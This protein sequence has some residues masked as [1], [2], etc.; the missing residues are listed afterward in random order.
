MAFAHECHK[1]HRQRSEV[2]LHSL[3]FAD[4]KVNIILLSYT[5]LLLTLHI[6]R[7]TANTN[8]SQMCR[9]CRDKELLPP[10]QN[11]L[12]AKKGTTGTKLQHWIETGV[13]LRI[14]KSRSTHGGHLQQEENM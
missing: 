6:Q 9:P 2:M 11:H 10:I 13:H 12:G 4:N 1:F 3:N 14:S 8:I 5:I 7:S